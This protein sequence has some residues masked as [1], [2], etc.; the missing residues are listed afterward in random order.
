VLLSKRAV[1][2]QADQKDLLNVIE[3]VEQLM[4][5]ATQDLLSKS[6]EISRALGLISDLA[7][8]NN[9]K[10]EKISDAVEDVQETLK[11]VKGYLPL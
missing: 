4:G 7:V 5:G 3:T 2:L 9:K 8:S 6:D 1:Q 11:I 10:L